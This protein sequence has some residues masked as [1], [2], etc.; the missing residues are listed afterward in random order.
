V[1]SLLADG[2]RE[3]DSVSRYG[4]E[5]FVV[6]LP[7]T[8]L[9]EAAKLAERL[10][11]LIA[12][13]VMVDIRLTV[14][15]GVTVVEDGDQAENILTRADAALYH[16]KSMG[17]NRIVVNDGQRMRVVSEPASAT[18]KQNVAKPTRDAEKPAVVEMPPVVQTPTAVES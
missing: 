6:L 17:R 11:Q 7:Q 10:R 4:G 2:V 12:D 13:T 5:E 9:E 16:A 15:G 14:S 3:S 1:A 8:G 18:E